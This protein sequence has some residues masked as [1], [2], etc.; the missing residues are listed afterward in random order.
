MNRKKIG[1]CLRTKGFSVKLLTEIWQSRVGIWIL[2]VL[3]GQALLAV[4]NFLIRKRGIL[5]GFKC[6]ERE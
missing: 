6:P 1:Y 2:V 5:Q 4:S 3:G